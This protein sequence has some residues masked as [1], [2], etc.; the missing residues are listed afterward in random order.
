MK[1]YEEELENYNQ[2]IIIDPGNEE[3]YRSK[4]ISLSQ[5]KRY[6]EAQPHK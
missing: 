6:V 4:G 5:L 2:A 1:R 3:V